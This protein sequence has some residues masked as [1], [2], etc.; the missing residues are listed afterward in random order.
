MSGI[1]TD[2]EVRLGD[3]LDND[4]AR[5]RRWHR[6][7]E[8]RI[9]RTAEGIFAKGT[10]LP[11]SILLD[12]GPEK[13]KRPDYHED[14]QALSSFRSGGRMRTLISAFFFDFFGSRD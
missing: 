6:D 14:S 12:P 2:L 4:R 11:C 5:L 10:L 8:I 7:G 1:V 9:V 3:D 13:R